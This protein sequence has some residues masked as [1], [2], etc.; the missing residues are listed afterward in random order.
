[1]I[2]T[3]EN[4]RQFK[5]R[6]CN[7]LIAEDRVYSDFGNPIERTLIG[8]NTTYCKCRK[9]AFLP[10]KE[11]RI[12]AHLWISEDYSI[13]FVYDTPS[14]VQFLEVDTQDSVCEMPFDDFIIEDLSGIINPAVSLDEVV[15][16]VSKIIPSLSFR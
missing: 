11:L 14:L 9:S 10:A 7:T 1:M 16:I 15:D 8:D 12:I 6:N 3:E 13:R 4:L 5:C 2:F